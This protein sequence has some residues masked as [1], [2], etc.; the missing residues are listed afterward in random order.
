MHSLIG[1]FWSFIT[2]MAEGGS[3]DPQTLGSIRSPLITHT[4]TKP[5][6]KSVRKIRRKSS[7]TRQLDSSESIPSSHPSIFAA[8]YYSPSGSDDGG[9]KTEQ[10]QS[11][12]S[13]KRSST[14]EERPAPSL[15]N[16][17]NSDGELPVG[18]TPII[19]GHGT[20]LSTIIEQK[21]SLATIRASVNTPSPATLTRPRSTS[22]LSSSPASASTH[23]QPPKTSLMKTEFSIS[24]MIHRFGSF[25]DEDVSKM[26]LSWPEGYDPTTS[27]GSTRPKGVIETSLE[28]ENP[29]MQNDTFYEIYAQ[30][31]Q[32]LQ[33][34]IDRPA[35][36]PGMPSWTAAQQRRP[37]VAVVNPAPSN[38]DRKSVV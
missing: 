23:K 19:Y 1:W 29:E 24:G 25:S 12:S 33:P 13:M 38:G 20:A 6:T 31:L 17:E 11:I 3:Q 14:A 37:R 21:S 10:R 9:Y 30:P 7:F 2:S 35:T 26:K 16:D 4:N 27:K 15:G 32:P 18:N 5:L 22:D 34:P 8:E 36:P 28:N